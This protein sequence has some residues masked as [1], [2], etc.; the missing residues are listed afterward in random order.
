MASLEHSV[1]YNALITMTEDLYNDLPIS[2]YDLLPRLISYRVISLQDKID[3]RSVS[4]DRGKIQ[5]LMSKLTGEMVSGNNERFY[6]FLTAMKKSAKCSFLVER[7]ER[8]I[9]YYRQ[10]LLPSDDVPVVSPTSK[11]DHVY[12]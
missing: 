11:G 10:Q 4:N 2:D 9:S 8:W 12:Y 3:I 7:M 1:E 6:K 5:L